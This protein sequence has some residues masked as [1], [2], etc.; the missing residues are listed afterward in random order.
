MSPLVSVV[1]PTRGRPAF[2]AEALDSVLVQTFRDFEVV[3]VEDGSRDAHEVVAGRDPRVRYVWQ[4]A[5]GVSVARNTGVGATT[6]DWIAFLDDD[7]RWLP[8]K[9]ERQLGLA[10]TRPEVALVHTEFRWLASSTGAVRPRR[11]PGPLPREGPMLGALVRSRPGF[12]LLSSVLVRRAAVVACGGF[13]PALRLCQD[14]DLFL[15]IAIDH[16]FGYVDE[17]LA[18]YRRHRTNA[19]A[20]ELAA[21]AARV[22]VLE[23]FL[24]RHPAARARLRGAHRRPLGRAHL[25]CARLAAGLH[26]FDAVRFHTR[27][28]LRWT[29][30]SPKA[31]VYA[32]ACAAGVP[33]LRA[34]ATLI[35]RRYEGPQTAPED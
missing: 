10:T 24:R 23:R 7:D 4:P 34:L 22:T 28:A 29:P 8:T 14:Y 15:R 13:D 19:T 33:G 26:A 3:V 6:G 12:I 5:Q 11:D 31:L 17:P 32:T 9:L 16:P 35:R 2:L 30:L 27:R 18:L 20:D 1:V 25:G 21:R